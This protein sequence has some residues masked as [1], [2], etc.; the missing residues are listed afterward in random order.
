MAL[1]EVIGKSRKL[2]QVPPPP[3]VEK[4][5]VMAPQ[6]PVA[7]G[8]P[9]P[10]AAVRWHAKPRVVQFN[11]GRIEMS[12]P[13]PVALVCVLGVV[14]MVLVA[15][16]LGQKPAGVL[17][18]ESPQTPAADAGRQ[19]Q[20]DIRL[21]ERSA[22]V[23]VTPPPAPV[24]PAVV[25]KGDNYIVITQYLT[26]RDLK[27]V[28]EHFARFGIETV[29]ENTGGRY[30]L[31]TKELYESPLKSGSDGSV[32]LKRIREVGAQYKALQ[33]YES[34]RPNLFS[35]AYGKKVK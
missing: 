9:E 20:A 21:P 16:R 24:K 15:F 34:F 4:P 22:P 6:V 17:P 14:A 11:A 23:V 33:G 2:S 32:A 29:I 3:Q 28:Q 1:Y 27:P 7:A 30:F 19:A 10:K 13:Y 12:V 18:A 35:D 5:E 26:D 31:V 25:S 8:Q